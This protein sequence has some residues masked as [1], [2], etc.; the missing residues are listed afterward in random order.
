MT[1]KERW[2]YLFEERYIANT[3]TKEIHD[4]MKVTKSCGIERIA[5]HNR[6]YISAWKCKRLLKR[7]YNGCVWCM[8]DKDTDLKFKD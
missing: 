3:H 8:K 5:V 6:K 4:A 2:Q 1:L 7:G